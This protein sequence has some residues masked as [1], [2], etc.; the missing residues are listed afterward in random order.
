MI[1][2]KVYPNT[3]KVMADQLFLDLYETQ[4]IKLTI[5]IEDI[6]NADATSTFS[7]VFKV[8][9]TRHNEEFFK[10]AFLVNGI[11]Y[12]IT[13]KKPAEILVDGAEFKVGHIRL[14]KIYVNGDQDKIDYELLFLGETRS[15][16]AIIADKP[17]C[18]LEMEDILPPF[19]VPE[20][21]RGPQ[22][23]SS[24]DIEDVRTSWQAFPQS[25]SLTAGLCNGNLL[26]PLINHGNTYDDAGVPLQGEIAIAGQKPFTDPAN[27]LST[28]RFKPMIRAKRVIDQIFEEAGYTYTSE[29]FESDR[30]HQQY[31]SAFGNL[32]Q[33][34]IVINQSTDTQFSASESTSQAMDNLEINDVVFN[35]STSYDTGGSYSKYTCS[36]ANTQEAF[37]IMDVEVSADAQQEDSDYGTSNLPWEVQIYNN[38]TDTVLAYANGFGQETVS[39][40]WDSR[41]GPDNVIDVDDILITR[42]E[43]AGGY[44]DYSNVSAASWSCTA[45]P[46]AYNL[47][48]DLDCDYKQIDFIKDMLTMFRLVMQ[49]DVKKPNNFIVEPWQAFIGSGDTF[50]WSQKL[51]KDKDFV[52]EPLFNNQSQ[53]IDFSMM[54]DEDYINQFHQDNYKHPYGWL[55]FN[56]A[57]E[58]LKGNKKIEVKGIS[59][60]PLEQIAHNSNSTHPYPEWVIPIIHKYDT[61]D[62]ISL[63]APIKPNSRLMFYNGLQTIEAG[64]SNWYTVDGTGTQ[65]ESE[66]PLCSPYETWPVE[67]SSLNLNFFN[68]VRYYL[69]GTLTPYSDYTAQGQTLFTAY[70][71][72]YISS[73]YNKYSRKVTANFILDDTDLRYLTFD[74]LIFINGVYYRPQKINNAQVGTKSQVNVELITVLDAKPVWKNEPLTGVS[75]PIFQADCGPEDGG[76]V[77]VYTNGTPPFEIKLTN[78]ANQNEVITTGGGTPGNAPYSYYIYSEPGNFDVLITD[79]LNRKWLEQIQIE[80]N[81]FSNNARGTLEVTNATDCFEPNCNGEVTVTPITSTGGGAPYTI[82]WSDTTSTSFTRTGLCSDTTYYYNLTGNNGCESRYKPVT[83]GCDA[84]SESWEVEQNTSGNRSFIPYVGNESLFVGQSIDFA[85][86]PGNCFTVLEETYTA[87]NFFDAINSY[88]CGA[89]GEVARIE[90]CDTQQVYNALNDFNNQAGDT[91]QYQDN[92]G[93]P[94]RC[95]TILDLY[96]TGQLDATISNGNQQTC[97]QGVCS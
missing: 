40:N 2:L 29:F 35:P 79:A 56:S 18:Q 93:G 69:D 48:G 51:V 89:Q 11:T 83:I 78:L 30:F 14:Q 85:P 17:L 94:L 82:T 58:L 95:G 76:H 37:Y 87:P 10:N 36:A 71:S 7:K 84:P 75:M 63:S 5:S 31:L 91:I 15:F 43:L 65:A 88:A 27:A 28:S 33:I 57:N 96:G 13:T 21:A 49:P 47:T 46:G 8:P 38:T 67:E 12:D 3:D 44:A 70:W 53:T 6:T 9:A 45:A 59:P 74:D 20:P 42:V 39:L 54:A 26:F 4:P 16:S 72:R 68:D 92:Q 90:D 77:R 80:A 81:D 73:I 25:A 86:Q 22:R 64:Q 55:Q 66:W 1:Q 19:I 97:G 34:G 60:T 50:D 23:K 41:T 62:G 32:E 52:I 61:Q 24:F